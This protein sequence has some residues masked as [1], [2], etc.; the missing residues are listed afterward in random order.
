MVYLSI[1]KNKFTVDEGKKFGFIV[2]KHG[3]R[4]EAKRTEE[5]AKIP[6]PRKKNSM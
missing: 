3:M 1:P 5:N 6:P 4:I 2:S